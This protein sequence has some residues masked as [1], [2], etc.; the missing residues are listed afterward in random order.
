LQYH[1]AFTLKHKAVVLKGCLEK[2]EITRCS[3]FEMPAFVPWQAKLTEHANT[4][5]L[6]V[7]V[8]V[9]LPWAKRAKPMYLSPQLKLGVVHIARIP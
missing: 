5:N 9:A 2:L 3:Y 4:V 6:M 7:N 1:P 8:R